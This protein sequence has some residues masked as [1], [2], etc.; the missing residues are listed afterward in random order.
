MVSPK[1]HMAAEKGQLPQM[2]LYS[3]VSGKEKLIKQR[4]NEFWQ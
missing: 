3:N 4:R 2:T 1:V